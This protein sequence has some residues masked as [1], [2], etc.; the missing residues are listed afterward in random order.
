MD[1]ASYQPRDLSGLIAQYQPELVIVRLYLPWERPSQDHSLAQVA[2]ARA[3]GCDVQGYCWL[4]R[5][6]RMARVLHEIRWLAVRAQ[7]DLAPVLW[8]DIETYE[9]SMPTW[10]A[11]RRYV[12]EC[13]AAQLRP[14]IYSSAEMWRRGGYRNLGPEVLL[15][16]ARSGVE[17]WAVE[18]FGGMSLVG[19]QYQGSPLD[20]SV[21]LDAF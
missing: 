18:P 13:R 6:D 2:S 4:Y 20:V 14:G 15:W 16:A 7:L 11:L 9:G 10:Y 1:V 12:A 19:H 21:F 3:N 8:A 17:P 5:G